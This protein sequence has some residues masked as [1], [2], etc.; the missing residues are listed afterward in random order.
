MSNKIIDWDSLI[1]LCGDEDMIED[2]MDATVDDA[3]QT[4]TLLRNA[5]EAKDI[6][7]IE[8]Y[9]HRMKGVSMVMG[10]AAFT[11]LAHALEMAGSDGRLDDVPRLFAPIQET[12]DEVVAFLSQ[13]N[14]IE[15]A[16]HAEPSPL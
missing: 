12:F 1:E 16:K 9:A 14:W 7:N 2:L 4:L 3:R 5:V 13:E 6:Q 8:L 11:P 10:A 15:L